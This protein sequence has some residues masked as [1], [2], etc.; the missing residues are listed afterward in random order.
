MC[1]SF[2]PSS[3]PVITS[4]P[5]EDHTYSAGNENAEETTTITTDKVV[6]SGVGGNGVGSSNGVKGGAFAFGLLQGTDD[7]T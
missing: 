5:S 6:S 2:V 1:A 7:R 4:S 3:Q